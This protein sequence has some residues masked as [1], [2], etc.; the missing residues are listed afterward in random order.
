MAI[1]LTAVGRTNCCQLRTHLN[2]VSPEGGHVFFERHTN[3]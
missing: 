2:L 1:R 3:N